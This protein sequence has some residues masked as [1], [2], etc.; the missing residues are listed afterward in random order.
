M[1]YIKRLFMN[2]GCVHD[3]LSFFLKLVLLGIKKWGRGNQRKTLSLFKG[4]NG[5]KSL[6]FILL[7]LG[8]NSCSA[9]DEQYY[10]LHPKE[11][12][13]AVKTCEQGKTNHLSCQKIEKLAIRMNG[14]AYQLQINPQGFGQKILLLQQ[15]IASQQK[16]LSQDTS[17]S[18]LKENI[19]QN[20]KELAELLS[21]VKW[22][23]SPES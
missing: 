8:L 10:R 3:N 18:E 21:V 23:E 15:T 17:K 22:L 2:K 1:V 5:S 9:K 16:Q 19:I 11:L 4:F 7:T 13:S 12:Q 20:K 14:L 6:V